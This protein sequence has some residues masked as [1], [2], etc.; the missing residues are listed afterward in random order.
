MG[1]ETETEL[2]LIAG[3]AAIAALLREP[4]LF[5]GRSETR[6]V[7]TY[8]DTAG[9]A[10]A[11]AGLSLRVRAIGDRRV[12]TVKAER[13]TMASLFARDE[14]EREIAGDTPEP[15][16]LAEA[17]GDVP[18][19][20]LAPLFRTE[21]ERVKTLFHLDDSVIEMVADRGRVVAGAAAAPIGEVELELMSGDPRALFALARRIAA[22]APVRLGVES[23]SERGYALLR[24]KPPKAVKAEPLRL[25]R[26]G[27]AAGLFAAVAGAC[28]RHF[29]LNEDRLLATGGAEPLH[30]ARVA[31]RRLRSAL[32][33]FRDMLTDDRYEH[34]RGELRWL[35][36]LLGEVRNIDVL[37]PRITDRE[38]HATLTAA[39]ADALAAVTAALDSP[40]VRTLMLDLSEWAAFGAWRT[41]EATAALRATPARDYAAARLDRLAR[42]LRRRGRGLAEQDDEGRH[43]VRIS[44]KKLRYAAEF[45]ADLFPSAKR[46]RRRA[47]FLDRLE[48][49]QTALGDLNDLASGRALLAQLGLDDA[50]RL[51]GTGDSAPPRAL[52]AAAE[53]AHDAVSDGKRFWK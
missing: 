50:E 29:R 23:K 30:Q 21:V 28:L 13:A 38:A 25:D 53:S 24:V 45:F 12:Q 52:L 33:I 34:L 16:D 37:L 20:P 40:R 1:A 22:L 48:A 18:V 32:T 46:E 31:L 17:M 27:D 10:L 35:A 51:L 8:F 14:W 49:M 3:D 42:R 36:A 41:A 9:H 7:S 4:G 47:R 44:G 5:G 6:Q 26:D 43:E 19:D 11:A 2:K 15:A 39:R